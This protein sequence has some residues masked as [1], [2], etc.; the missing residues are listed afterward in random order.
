M[1][2][3]PGRT[4]PPSL[5]AATAPPAPATPPLQGTVRA[6]VAIV[7]AGYTGLSA[8]L[9]L[10]ER[11]TSVV[12]LDAGEP[13]WGASGRNGGQVIPGLKYDP[14]ELEAM[15][16]PE[17]G[18]RLVD[19]AG[20]VADLV[21]DLAERYAIACDPVRTGWLQ[22]AHSPT[23]KIN[24]DRRAQQWAKRGF[25]VEPLDRATMAGMLGSEAY[26][27]GWI[28]RRAGNIQPL[29]F[30]RGLAAAAISRG[31]AVHGGTEAQTL[32][33][34]EGQWRIEAP[35]G[36]SVLADCVLLCT[37]GYTDRLFPGL[38]RE[39]VSTNSYQAATRPLPA[40]IR[41]RILPGGQA[42][43]DT[44]RILLYYRLDRDGRFV[45]GG[46]GTATDEPSPPLFENLR[47]AARTIYP[48]LAEVEWG[49]HWSGRV[50]FTTDHLPH[51][52][53][54]GPG[55]LAGLGYQGRGVALATN[56]GKLLADR[57]HGTPPD[58][59]P[60]PVATRLQPFPFHFLRVPA[61]YAVSRWYRVLDHIN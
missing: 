42:A 43:S 8:A 58:D 25:D 53:E 14:D 47:R 22:P 30:A 45:I 5:W 60:L 27:G 10:A 48:A 36:A 18:P 50:C 19:F 16:G 13:G 28:D 46:R 39:V 33:R 37:N 41:A 34:E 3:A 44:R 23:A 24:V 35:G 17:R 11:G 20:R 21:F 56:L 52:I 1:A 51:L 15:F 12:V 2:A 57:V 4:P 59:L 6:D 55:L 31:A 49:N 38:E 7:G 54:L 40:S 9:H 32:R 61:L 26:C 29:A